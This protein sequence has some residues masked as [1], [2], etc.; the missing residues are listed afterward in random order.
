MTNAECSGGQDRNTTTSYGEDHIP[1]PKTRACYKTDGFDRSRCGTSDDGACP[2]AYGGSQACVADDRG[3]YCKKDDGSM[4]VSYG[5]GF[6]ELTPEKL[7]ER[8]MGTSGTGSSGASD[9]D[10]TVSRA[11]K[12]QERR[13]TN[14]IRELQIMGKNPIRQGSNGSNESNGSNGSNESNESNGDDNEVHDFVTDMLFNIGIGVV[15]IFFFISLAFIL[16]Q[17]KIILNN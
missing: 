11:L 16:I 14:R 10:L 9:T 3:G 13:M 7:L 15:A 4:H 6:T 1:P 17:N 5:T 12:A 2:G 8:Y